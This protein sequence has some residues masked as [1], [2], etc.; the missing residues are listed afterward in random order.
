MRNGKAIADLNRWLMEN[1]MTP[2]R[3]S[4]CIMKSSGYTRK[5]LAG[6]CTPTLPVARTI[7]DFTDGY[8]RAADWHMNEEAMAR[9]NREARRKLVAEAAARMQAKKEDLERART[10]VVVRALAS[11]E[12]ARLQE[13]RRKK[14]AQMDRRLAARRLRAGLSGVSE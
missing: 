9:E 12:R 4:F 5:I 14:A 6:A 13:V 1:Q 7:E 2:E 8:V 11:A 3:F 10:E